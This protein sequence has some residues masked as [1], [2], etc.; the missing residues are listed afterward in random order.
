MEIK[1]EEKFFS[2]IRSAFCSEGE[3]A[4]S[5]DLSDE[6]LSRMVK[7]ASSHD[8]VH[9]LAIGLEKCGIE[10]RD[11][12]DPSQ[13]VFTAIFRYEQLT[14]EYETLCKTL[15]KGKIPFMPLKG[16]VIRKYYPDAWMRTSC[17]VDV[18]VKKEDLEKASELL[19][20]ELGYKVNG[21]ATHDV[22][23]TTK[24]GISV[25]LHFD[26]VE[27][28]RAHKACEI[29]STVWERALP[30]DGGKYLYEMSDELFYF[31]HVAH[32]AKHFESGGCGVRPYIDLWILDGIDTDIQK[33]NELLS[34][35]GL[36]HFANVAR[37]LS[38]VWMDGAQHSAVSLKMSSFILRGGV[39]GSSE[40]R[41]NLMQK[42]KGGK[43]G[44]LL[45]RMFIPYERLVRY[46]PVLEK[47][48]WLMPVMQIR[49]W[50][51]LFDP[52]VRK[53]ARREI[54][55]NAS[56]KPE[57]AEAMGRFLSEIGLE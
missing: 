30:R 47:H 45:S 28:G 32:M 29:L 2:I 38:R 15:E 12:F 37:E 21:R 14:H 4:L 24:S 10:K 56:T 39:Y 19:C 51:M 46:Y 11:V 41:V 6:E 57:G 49:R 42:H 35:G 54:S 17:D 5:F 16:S 31:Y 40:N 13:G 18:L 25:E 55:V 48:R 8:I 36:L 50:F 7:I 23:M 33:R 34:K 27:E 53:M 44:Y 1:I 9:L 43:L 3:R 20:R 26:L 22:S 52:A